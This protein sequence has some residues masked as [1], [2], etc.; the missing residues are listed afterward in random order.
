MEHSYCES[1]SS[2]S[3]NSSNSSSTTAN[4]HTIIDEQVEEVA[5]NLEIVDTNEISSTNCKYI[6]ISESSEVKSLH[7]SLLQKKK[8]N[9]SLFEEN[10]SDSH[11][12]WEREDL[13]NEKKPKTPFSLNINLMYGSIVNVNYVDFN[14]V[15]VQELAVSF[16]NQTALGNILG[17]QDMWVPKG[18]VQKLILDSECSQKSS[19]EVV[20]CSESSTAYI[21][22]WIKEHKS[23]NRERPVA[24]VFAIVYFR[25][26]SKPEKKVLQLENIK[27]FG[28][29][30]RY[31]VMRSCRC[32]VVSWRVLD[33]NDKITIVHCYN[34]APD[35]QSVESIKELEKVN[36]YVTSLH[37]IEGKIFKTVY[38]H[39]LN[40][41]LSYIF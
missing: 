14:L 33:D 20:Y 29:D 22:L 35:F 4:S 23:F 19:N 26:S 41:T 17:S 3:I 31:V 9:D 37:N 18:S 21:E 12:N 40:F 39:D 10:S 11:S 16:W 8:V 36:H 25:K 27:G 13:V 2:D 7:K 34:L 32:V 15:V 1:E 5:V 38:F 30:V 24:D 6:P 28:E